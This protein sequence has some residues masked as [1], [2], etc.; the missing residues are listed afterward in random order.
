MRWCPCARKGAMMPLVLVHGG[1]FAASCWDLLLD[2][3]DGPVLAVDL[4]GRG[5]HPVPLDSVTIAGAAESLVADVDAAAFDEIVLV[6]HSLAGATMPA[7]IGLL[8][9]RV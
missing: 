6:G 3:V 9:D 2:H 4:P 7:A 1:G 5:A 8:G